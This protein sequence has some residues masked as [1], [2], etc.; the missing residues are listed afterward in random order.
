[1][2]LTTTLISLYDNLYKCAWCHLADLAKSVIS[3]YMPCCSTA[4]CIVVGSK[5]IRTCACSFCI[6]AIRLRFSSLGV[7]QVIRIAKVLQHLAGHGKTNHSQHCFDSTRDGMIYLTKVECVYVHA[8]PR[9]TAPGLAMTSM[10]A[11]GKKYLNVVYI[12]GGCVERF[13]CFVDLCF[14]EQNYPVSL[15]APNPQSLHAPH[16]ELFGELQH[17][18]HGPCAHVS[19]GGV[20]AGP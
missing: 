12:P 2:F 7:M 9:A 15:C 16:D 4:F 3:I 6:A 5:K 11:W 18:F 19:A 8:T 1:M 13:A 20:A 17:E 10:K 14:P